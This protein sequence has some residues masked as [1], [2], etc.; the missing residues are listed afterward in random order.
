MRTMEVITLNKKGISQ[1]IAKDKISPY[2]K[3]HVKILSSYF[4]VIHFSR[5]DNS[6]YLETL[7]EIHCNHSS[8]EKK[9][10]IACNNVF[11]ITH[12]LKDGM[13]DR[14][15]KQSILKTFQEKKNVL[16]HWKYN[17]LRPFHGSI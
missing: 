9:T 3:E 5:Q 6:V 12:D 14:R 10:G 16:V 7:V 4:F 2:E 8:K 13:L 11:E 17:Q 15:F 1:D